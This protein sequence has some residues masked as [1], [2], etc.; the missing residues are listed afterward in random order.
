MIVRIPCTSTDRLS[1]IATR[2]A[3]ESPPFCEI[4]L[5]TRFPGVLAT[6]MAAGVGKIQKAAAAKPAA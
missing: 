1:A 4:M 6:V 3:T 5:K 2:L